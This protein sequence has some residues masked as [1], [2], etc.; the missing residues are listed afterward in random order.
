MV[1]NINLAVIKK[2]KEDNVITLEAIVL[3]YEYIIISVMS[4]LYLYRE[5]RYTWW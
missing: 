1:K 5:E 4:Y 3:P 2:I